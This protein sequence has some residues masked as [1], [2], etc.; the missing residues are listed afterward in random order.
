MSQLGIPASVVINMLYKQ[1]IITKSSPFPL[2]I[3]NTLQTRDEI[4]DKEF[5][6]M[7]PKIIILI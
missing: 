1:I 6:A 2:S 4:P 3:S 7:M 5:D